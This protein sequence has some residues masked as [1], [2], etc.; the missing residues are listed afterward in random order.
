MTE[1]V[2]LQKNTPVTN[3]LIIAEETENS[4]QSVFRLVKKYKDD[5]EEFGVVGF[6]IH[7]PKKGS[8]G[9]RPIELAFLNE[10][11]TTLLLTYMRNSDIVRGFKKKLVKEFYKMRNV[12]SEISVRQQNDEWKQLRQNGKLTRK[13]ETDI[14]KLFVEYAKSQGSSKAEMYYSN[15]SK[16]ENKSLFFI[17]EKFPNLRSVLTGQ[18][19]QIMSSADQIVEKALKEGMEKKTNYKEIYKMA[20]ERIETFAD[21][22]PKTPVPMV[23]RLKEGK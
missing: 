14:I 2:K 16:M 13:K 15:I 4:H 21:I 20:K 1:L 18:Q 5:L 23:E 19:L 22:I 6:E 12:L 10:Q 7:K 8:N 17:Q 9:G 3:T 11:Q